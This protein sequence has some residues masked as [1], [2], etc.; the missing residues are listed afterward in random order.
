M[1]ARETNMARHIHAVPEKGI[2]RIRISRHGKA[3]RTGVGPC[4]PR[5]GPG[6]PHVVSVVHFHCGEVAHV[7]HWRH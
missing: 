5:V 6:H 7:A 3:A 2:V 1:H 4:V